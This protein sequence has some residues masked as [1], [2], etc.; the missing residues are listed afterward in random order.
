[1]KEEIHPSNRFIETVDVAPIVHVDII[2]GG[3]FRQAAKSTIG[4]RFNHDRDDSATKFQNARE[5]I[6]NITI[7][8]GV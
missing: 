2:V 1:M 6:D 7:W 8:R 4:I 5:T 3:D